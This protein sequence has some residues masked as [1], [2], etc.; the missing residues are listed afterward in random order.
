MPQLDK[1]VFM[2][3]LFWLILTF[4]TLY[5]FILKYIL[6][7]TAKTLKLR[8]KQ[9][10]LNKNKTESL[11]SD[12]DAINLEYETVIQKILNSSR[13]SLLDTIMLSTSWSSNVLKEI[14]ET[15]FKDANARFLKGS[16]DIIGKN[17]LIKNLIKTN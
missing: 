7:T 3:Q 15:L 2:S 6:P 10:L 14:N 9:I 12:R 17:Y 13:V 11:N 16:A 8:K 4:L 5:V 1:L